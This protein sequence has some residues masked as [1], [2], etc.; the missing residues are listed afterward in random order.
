MIEN[1]MIRPQ[2][3]PKIIGYCGNPYC[4]EEVFEGGKYLFDNDLYCCHTCIGEDLEI[5]GA[6]EKL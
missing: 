1:P 4:R 3:E 2:D 5:Q 6:V